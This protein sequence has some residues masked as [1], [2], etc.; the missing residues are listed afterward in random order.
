MQP[1]KTPF[2]SPFS[3]SAIVSNL[4]CTSSNGRGSPFRC[5]RATAPFGRSVSPPSVVSSYAAYSASDGALPP[6]AAEPQAPF[7]CSESPPSEASNH[8]SYSAARGTL[9]SGAAEPQLPSDAVRV[10]P[11]L[12]L[13]FFTYS[14]SDGAPPTG[15][16]EPRLPS[17]LTGLPLPVQQ[18]RGSLRSQ[19]G[20]S[21]YHL[22]CAAC[23]VADRALPPGAAEPRLPSVAVGAPR[24]IHRR[25]GDS[26]FRC[27]RA[28]APFGHSE[29][30]STTRSESFWLI[31]H[32]TGL[33]LP[34]QQGHGSLR[35]QC[36]PSVCRLKLHCVLG[37]GRGSPSRCS[38]A[39]A[40]F[41]RSGGPPP[42]TSS[43][44]GLSLPVQQSRSSLRKQRESLH[45]ST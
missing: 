4:I 33:P 9:P 34:V 14:T 25:K 5:S 12:A 40:P 39:V 26:R 23:S 38:R 13:N 16:A 36:E 2:W 6:R 27:S 20:P 10:P 11:S 3:P 37:G 18:S 1:V 42:D 8:A 17:H 19:C 30:P 41:G 44:G 45:L 28:E 29:S 43:Q 22:S 35:S 15:A 21:V 32:R 31:Q 7:G 24:P